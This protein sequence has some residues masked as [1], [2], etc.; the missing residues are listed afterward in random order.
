MNGVIVWLHGDSLSPTDP[1]LL[2]NPD[3]PAIFVF[4]EPFLAAAQLSF[5]R[6]FFSTNVRLKQ[7][8]VGMVVSGVVSWLMK[9]EHLP[10]SIRLQP[11]T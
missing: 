3:A 10:P 6:L 1:A 4:D 5:K 8:L 9:C 7:L 2:A 11:S